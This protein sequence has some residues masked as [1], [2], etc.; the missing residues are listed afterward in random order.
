LLEKN[1]PGI[2]GKVT[3]GDGK[4]V[5]HI[6]VIA[7][8]SGK[9]NAATPNG[10]AGDKY[11]GITDTEGNYFIPLDSEGDFRIVARDSLGGSPDERSMFGTYSGNPIQTISFKRGQIIE[12]VNI[13]I[14]QATS[15]KKQ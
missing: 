5:E 4:P 7:F 15:K 12:G 10:S 9:N 14:T 3:N 8:K 2:K 13:V 11:I 1:E 6:Y